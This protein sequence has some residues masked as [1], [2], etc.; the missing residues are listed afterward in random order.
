[1][2]AQLSFLYNGITI[3]NS[4]TAITGGDFWRS[5]PRYIMTH[6][7]GPVLLYLQYVG[8]HLYFYP[9][10]RDHD[11]ADDNNGHGDVYPA[12][13]PYMIVSQGSS[14]SDRVFMNAVGATLAALR[15]EVK[16]KLAKTGT[17]M[18]AVQMIFRSS[19]KM[20]TSPGTISPVR[21]TLPS[22]K[23]ARSTRR[24]W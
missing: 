20:V 12:N 19:N 5:Q 10:H 9:E 15:P 6:P 7:R 21:H 23:A 11:P 22:S 24:R 2:G 4:S 18:A 8:N 3:G 17:L 1:M 13:T 16:Q 14:G